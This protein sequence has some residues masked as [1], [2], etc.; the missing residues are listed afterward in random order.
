MEFEETQRFWYTHVARNAW[1]D[2]SSWTVELRFLERR[3]NLILCFSLYLSFF[4]SL[5]SLFFFFSYSPL[6][7]TE[8]PSFVCSQLIFSFIIFLLF[9]SF[10]LF[11]HFL[12]SFPSFSLFS[13]FLIPFDFPSTELIKVGKLPPT[14][15]TCHMSSLCFFLIFFIFFSCFI[16]SYNIW[17]NVSHLSQ[18][19]HM[20]HT[21]C[22]FPRVPCVIPP[23]KLF[24][25]NVNE[26]FIVRLKLNT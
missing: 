26:L 14:F 17:L 15:L 8:P 13:S 7:P 11:L 23:I 9:L 5:I 21:M 2:F 25:K 1:I 22:H 12:L 6:L 19:H 18:V 3:E 16:T 24:L 4:L 10:S 20:D